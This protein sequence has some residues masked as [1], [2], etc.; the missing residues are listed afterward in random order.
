MQSLL[1]ADE[2]RKWFP[3][4][5]SNP[6]VD[7]VKIAQMTVKYLEYSQNLVGKAVAG[8]EWTDS[9]FERSFIR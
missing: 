9:N 1:L 7:T 4:M 6:A 8:S 5:E 2:Q 3:E